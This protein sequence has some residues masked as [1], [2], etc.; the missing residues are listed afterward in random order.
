MKD[1]ELNLVINPAH[2]L[3]M[4][5]N[6][7]WLDKDGFYLGCNQKVLDL[8]Q[9]TEPMVIGKNNKK[10]IQEDILSPLHA[11]HIDRS[12]QY[13][14]TQKQP[15]FN[16]RD[17]VIMKPGGKPAYYTTHRFPLFD[18]KKNLSGIL[19]FSLEITSDL[20]VK[21]SGL[22]G[23]TIMAA[24]SDQQ[25]KYVNEIFSQPNRHKKTSTINLSTQE[26]RCIFYLLKGKSAREIGEILYRST[27]TI[28]GHLESVKQKLDCTTRSELFDRVLNDIELLFFVRSQIIS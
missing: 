4:D 12:N 20:L 26:A 10:L 21:Q 28:E 25:H 22:F 15:I 16:V 27:R 6:V 7:Y 8:F 9:I 2:L 1:D 24:H 13:V 19:G 11:A 14:F 18:K 3:G 23:Y 17:P 5:L